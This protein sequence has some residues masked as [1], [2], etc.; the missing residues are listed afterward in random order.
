MYEEELEISDIRINIINVKA[1]F[2]TELPFE[3][4]ISNI[5]D[6]KQQIL[7]ERCYFVIYYVLKF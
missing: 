5:N 6:Q 3:N 7:Y 2:T 1:Y 4:F